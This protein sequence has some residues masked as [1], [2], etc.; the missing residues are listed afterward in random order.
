MRILSPKK[1]KCHKSSGFNTTLLERHLLKKSLFKNVKMSQTFSRKLRRSYPFKE[2]QEVEIDVE[3]SP[4]LL[5]EGNSRRNALIVRSTL[6]TK[7]IL[8]YKV[9]KS[10]GS[11]KRKVQPNTVD[12]H[13]YAPKATKK[14][15]TI[16]VEI[17][18]GKIRLNLPIERKSCLSKRKC[19]FRVF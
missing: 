11:P 15:E 7:G 8:I 17:K 18:P 14:F 3:V 19:R 16:I 1:Q 6:I 9:L 10:E 12:L 2:P 5:V 4:S 13:I